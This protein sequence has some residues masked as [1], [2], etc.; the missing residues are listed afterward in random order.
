MVVL[1]NL[2]FRLEVVEEDGVFLW[3]FILVFDDDVRVVDNFVGVIFM[4]EDVCGRELVLV[5]I[6]KDCKGYL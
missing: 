6:L 4:V 2:S 1:R 3:F 5:V